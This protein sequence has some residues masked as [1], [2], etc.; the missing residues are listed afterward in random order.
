MAV[1]PTNLQTVPHKTEKCDLQVEPLLW[2]SKWIP[3][4]SFCAII[5]NMFLISP[6]SVAKLKDWTLLLMANAY[7]LSISS[8][9]PQFTQQ[10]LL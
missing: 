7:R 2:H 6:S 10:M 4:K 5:L 9:V 3:S 8:L 1:L